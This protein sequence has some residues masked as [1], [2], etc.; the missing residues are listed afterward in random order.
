MNNSLSIRSYTKQTKTHRHTYHQLVLP[1][2]GSISIE[3]PTYAGSVS[4]GECV[5][6]R[7]GEQHCFKADEAAR[8]VVADMT[9]LP[10]NINECSEAVFATNAPL[11]SYL[12]FVD[13]QLTY[14][15][16]A[17]VEQSLFHLFEQLLTQQ[18]LNTHIDPRIRRVQSYIFEHLDAPLTISNLAEK[19]HLSPTQFK[20]LFKEQTHKSPLDFVMIQRMEKAKALLT[21]SDSPI[22]LVAEQVGYTDCS[23]FSRRFRQY[24]GLSPREFTTHR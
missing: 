4:V 18:S 10:S 22:G 17:A 9:T 21:H 14:Q 20:K 5:V 11:Q 24:V 13:L 2:Q 7:S 8:F 3:I 15:V 12:L 6:I 23:A 19:A 1:I 16:N